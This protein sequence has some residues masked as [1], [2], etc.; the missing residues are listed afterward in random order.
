MSLFV[1]KL[2]VVGSS[3]SMCGLLTAGIASMA[4]QPSPPSAPAR[5]AQDE[6]LDL[7]RAWGDALVHNDAAL[8]DRIVA[9]EM[10]GTDPAGHRWNKA[11]YL[12]SVKSGAFKIESFELADMKVH[13]YGDAAV[14]TGRPILNKHS[15]SGFP[16]GAAV[17]TDTY[18][19]RNGCWQCVAWQS[20]AAPAQVQTQAGGLPEQR[21]PADPTLILGATKAEEPLPP[22]Q[23]LSAPPPAEV[24]GAPPLFGLK[25]PRPIIQELPPLPPAESP[26]APASPAPKTPTDSPAQPKPSAE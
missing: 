15:K 17:F 23:Q 10:V 24:P 16:P 8:M 5:T 21:P 1:S 11:E 18:V 25:A 20:A 13:V 4:Q 22:I 12:E 14:A 9:Y 26:G 7:E 3:L 2:K 6:V 19:R